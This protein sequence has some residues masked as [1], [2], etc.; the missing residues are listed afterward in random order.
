MKNTEENFGVNLE[1]LRDFNDQKC[2]GLVIQGAEHFEVPLDTNG[3]QINLGVPLE[4]LQCLDTADILALYAGFGQIKK[5][6]S[7]P[8]RGLDFTIGDLLK[9]EPEKVIPTLLHFSY[10][11]YNGIKE[12]SKKGFT[13]FE[14]KPIAP[15]IE[16]ISQDVKTEFRDSLKALKQNELYFVPH[17]NIKELFNIMSEIYATKHGKEYLW[18]S[19]DGSELF[20]RFKMRSVS[21]EKEG[22]IYLAKVIPKDEKLKHECSC[23]DWRYTKNICKHIKYAKTQMENIK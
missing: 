10:F 21:P 17:K 5:H 9:E 14:R 15:R 11:Y 1:D 3:N 13:R 22:K 19:E 23:D 8:S 2:L 16:H 4:I 7:I 6:G 18:D 20:R 12:M